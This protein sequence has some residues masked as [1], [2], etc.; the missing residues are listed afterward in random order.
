MPQKDNPTMIKSEI[1]SEG[2]AE[3]KSSANSRRSKVLNKI[4]MR[5]ITEIMATGQ[6]SSEIVGHRIEINRVSMC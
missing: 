1:F 6:H 3:G 4:F 2:R 5:Y